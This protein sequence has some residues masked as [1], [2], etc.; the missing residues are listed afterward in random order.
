MR[1]LAVDYEIRVLLVAEEKAKRFHTAGLRDYVDFYISEKCPYCGRLS[2]IVPQSPLIL[3]EETGR[4]IKS[5]WDDVSYPM[6]GRC[7][8]CGKPTVVGFEV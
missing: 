8:I 4:R 2:L 5:L 3:P 7:T 6:A 1:N